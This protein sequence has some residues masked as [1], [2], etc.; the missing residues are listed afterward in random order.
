[1]QIEK[2]CHTPVRTWI[3]DLIRGFLANLEWNYLNLSFVKN[4]QLGRGVKIYN[5]CNIFGS[6]IGDG[7]QIASFVE[8]QNNTK[9]GKRCK[10]GA[11]CF[12]PEGT[13]LEDEIFLGVG[14]KICNDRVPMACVN[15]KLKE[16]KDWRLSPVTIKTGASVGAN[17]TILPGLTIGKNSLLGAGS[18]LTKDMGDNELW[19][20]NPA[21]LAASNFQLK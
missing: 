1:M 7:T 20:G 12:I 10:I 4:T 16:K 19:Y 2:E 6:N 21:R 18:V 3:K 13:I 9:I 15:G 17:C 5:H 14:T 8:I 11:Y